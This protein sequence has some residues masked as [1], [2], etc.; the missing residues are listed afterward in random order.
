MNAYHASART[1]R[2]K[3]EYFE[4]L[5]RVFLENDDTQK[6]YYSVV[7][8]F[9]EWAASHGWSSADIGIDLVATLADGSG[10]AAIQCKFHAPDHS[11][12]KPDIDSFISAASNERFT[13]LTIVD[14]TRKN[15][16]RNAKSTLDKLSKDWNRIGINEL[17]ASRIDWSRFIHTGKVGLAPKKTIR[18]HQREALAAVA[19]GLGKADRGKLIMACGT[20]KTFTALRIAETLAGNGKRVLFMVPSLALMSQ[21]VREWKNDCQED[22]TA[23]S[24]CS[25]AKVGRRVDPDSLDLNVHDLAF[26]ATTDPEKIAKQVNDARSERMTVVF[27]TYHSIDVLTRAQQ[28]FGLPEFDLVICDEAHRTTGVTLKDEDDSN[29]VRI[30]SND[31]VAAKKRL[32]MTATPRIFAEAAKRKADD[33][34]AELASMDD[35]TKFG[36]KTF[37]IEDLAGPS[38]TSC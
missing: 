13:R 35:A 8:P 29:F 20:G 5:A 27:S 18:D 22:F 6:Q 34:G 26:P 11:I 21:T 37:S 19:D 7:V 23:F 16:G 3:G 12:Q 10:F 33:H 25:D 14:T 1:E 17:E 28:Q 32:Y 30:H 15:F 24:A 36:V 4:R 9:A 31:Y 38:R 2:E